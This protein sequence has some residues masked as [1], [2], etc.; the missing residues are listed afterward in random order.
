MCAKWKPL[1]YLIP[2]FCRIEGFMRSVLFPDDEPVFQFKVGS[3]NKNR[4]I[5]ITAG[6]W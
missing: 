3:K 2:A 4:L 5:L 6:G 1:D